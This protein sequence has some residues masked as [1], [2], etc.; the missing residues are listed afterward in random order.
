M[1]SAKFDTS[2]GSGC[3]NSNAA[4]AREDIS[5]ARLLRE[6]DDA[7]GVVTTKDETTREEA[8]A[9]SSSVQE[10]DPWGDGVMVVVEVRE[11]GKGRYL[12]HQKASQTPLSM[13]RFLTM[14]ATASRKKASDERISRRSSQSDFSRAV[15][16]FFEVVRRPPKVV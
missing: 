3:S 10:S 6:L 12:T 7:N 9:T 1:D 2:V 13:T 4:D 15:K 5:S 11:V 16:K 14:Y 8:A